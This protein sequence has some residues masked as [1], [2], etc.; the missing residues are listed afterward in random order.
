M[1]KDKK[2]FIETYG[3]QMNVHDSEKLA[4]VLKERGYKRTEKLEDADV[5]ILN[6]CCIREKA[7][8]KVYGK[9]GQLKRLKRENPDLIIG[10]CGC[11]MQQEHVVKRI[12]SKFRHVDI[13]FGTHNIHHFANL[14]DKAKDDDSPLIKVWDK[15][16]ELIPQMP[17]RRDEDHKAWVT[18]IYGCNNFCT[19]CIVPYV[20]GR[21]KS[22]P[23]SSIVDEV[24]GLVDDGVKEV[25]L[26][27]QN[28]NSYGKDFEE[29]VD[30]ADL[31]VSLN[32]IKGLARIRYMTPHPK[33]F[34]DKLVNVTS[35]LDKVCEHFHLPVQAGSNKILK[36]MNRGYT[37]EEYL[38]LID[39]I[40][41]KNSDVAI[42]TDVIV[43][44]PGEEDGDFAETLSLFKEVEYD[45]A[46]SF[47]YS[48]RS[49]TPAAEREDQVAE[50][51]KKERLQRLIDIQSAI[52]LKKNKPLL[53][54]EVKVLVDGKS[55]KDKSKLSGRTRTNK[56]VIFAGSEELIGN[57]VNVKIKDVQ[58]WT[59]FGDMI[60]S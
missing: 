22:R 3:C 53:N 59:L 27:G 50:E 8:M 35:K 37:R 29:E 16:K 20:R 44:F 46:Y 57:I 36:E 33:D 13:V 12:K 6:T 41:E 5:I 23:L 14:L 21:E 10:V 26:L 60:D 38:E 28:V 58:S 17:V 47:I 51:V 9:I 2:Y 18:I 24:K 49:G 19:Y 34:S 52:S 25:T 1:N 7:E 30:F 56:I 45:M 48:K 32:E 42:T 11:M 54:Q 31:L 15:S 43:G 40:R 39:K 55:K 4:G